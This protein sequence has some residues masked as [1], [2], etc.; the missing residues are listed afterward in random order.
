M[1][2]TYTITGSANVYDGD[3]TNTDGYKMTVTLKWQSLTGYNED[4]FVST[5]YPTGK[6]IDTNPAVIGTC[7][8]TLDAEGV[9]LSA[10]VVTEGNYAICHWLY[11]GG[12][13][14]NTGVSLGGVAN[15]DFGET[16]YLTEAEW[17]TEGSKITG[18]TIQ[19]LGSRITSTNGFTLSETNLSIFLDASNYQ[20]EWYQPTFS[21]Y[22]SNSI[23]RR[24]NGG[25]NDG[26]KVKGWCVSA[27]LL[28]SADTFGV[29][30]SDLSGVV[31]LTGANMLTTSAIALG[32]VAALAM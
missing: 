31:T 5:A 2:T 22:Y 12:I 20:M 28:T 30:V 32:V 1:A 3:L 17:G 10:G 15:T 24:Y 4:A 14:D 11:Y 8:E 18:Q 26:D 21:A 16:R 19:T 9:S 27:R 6:P 13:S 7:V 25:A 23:L 29:T